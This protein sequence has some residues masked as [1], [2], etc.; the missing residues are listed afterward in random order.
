[1]TKISI[2]SSNTV[3]VHCLYV[4]SRAGDDWEQ[5]DRDAVISEAANRFGN[6]TI[7]DVEGYWHGRSIPTIALR[8]GTADTARVKLLANVIGRITKQ[9][10]VGLELNGRYQALKINPS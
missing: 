6:F 2:Q 4:G 7:G 8:I 3:P 10:E 1:M 5:S 9:K